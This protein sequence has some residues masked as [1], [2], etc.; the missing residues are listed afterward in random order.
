MK[1]NK[2]LRTSIIS[3][4]MVFALICTGLI[5]FFVMPTNYINLTKVFVNV[6]NEIE[7]NNNKLVESYNSQSDEDLGGENQELSSVKMLSSF[8]PM[9]NIEGE[10]DEV[11]GKETFNSYLQDINNVMGYYA[12]SEYLHEYLNPLKLNTTYYYD[13]TSV[14][15]FAIAHQMNNSFSFKLHNDY[16]DIEVNIKY[17]K[18]S[19]PKAVEFIQRNIYN[20]DYFYLSAVIDFEKNTY[21]QITLR[22]DDD[23]ISHNHDKG[24]MKKHVKE[25]SYYYVDYNDFSKFDGYI[26][27]N[28]QEANAKDQHLDKMHNQIGKHGKFKD[29]KNSE[30]GFNKKNPVTFP[31]AEDLQV[32][33]FN[34]YSVTLEKD[35][36]GKQKLVTTQRK[37][38]NENIRQA[39]TSFDDIEIP[40]I[41][42]QLNFEH[43]S[44]N[45]RKNISELKPD[46]SKASAN[47]KSWFE[48]EYDPEQ[49]YF[50]TMEYDEFQLLI[51]SNRF[52]YAELFDDY[53]LILSIKS[54]DYEWEVKYIYSDERFVVYSE[55]KSVEWK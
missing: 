45:L 26:I 30:K 24:H 47:V 17:D 19:Q 52:I 51:T 3:I 13:S 8:K 31:A 40:E 5:V 9:S 21:N 34:K 43:N 6:G 23:S 44:E 54:F 39:A 28:M 18:E 2:K 42:N 12:I 36:N 32:Y 41:F 10:V 11:S 15:Y 25:Y 22:S 20:E 50:K 29:F 38:V 7:K 14:K 35:R 27:K 33:A 46:M 48:S 53:K 55:L 16:E 1:N 49:Y 37:G 4:V